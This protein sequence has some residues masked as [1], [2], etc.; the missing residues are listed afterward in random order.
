MRSRRV[1]N[2]RMHKWL[3]KNSQNFTAK[4]LVLIVNNKFNEDFT[5]KQM[6][7]YFWHHPE[8]IYRYEK[9]NKKHSNN[10]LPIGSERRKSDG[11]WQI[12]VGPKKWEY[13]QRKIYEDYYGVK[14]KDD[15]YIIFLDQDRNNFDI[16]NLKKITRRESATMLSYG[17]FS[18]NPMVTETGIL[19][20]RTKNKM[21]DV[22]DRL[23]GD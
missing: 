22:K 15:E 6:Q 23:K 20:A 9:P 2:E 21:N 16:S 7:Q 18:K 19:V 11:M 13:K 4:E 1:F 12:K 14:L 3:C 10:P 17:L 8:L 5:L